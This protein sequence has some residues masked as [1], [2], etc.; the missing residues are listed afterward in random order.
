MPYTD[1]WPQWLDVCAICVVGITRLAPA[2]SSQALLAQ[3][4]GKIPENAKYAK[5]HCP[6]NYNLACYFAKVQDRDSFYEFV[7][8][9][10][11]CYEPEVFLADPDFSSCKTDPIFLGVLQ[12]D[13]YLH[14]TWWRSVWPIRERYDPNLHSDP[15]SD[16]SGRS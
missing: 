3:V 4:L 15:T 7:R 10:R 16:G 6:L 14:A 13:S 11:F 9:S 2:S 1:D 8:R 12:D 5:S